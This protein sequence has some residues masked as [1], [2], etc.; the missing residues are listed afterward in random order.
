ARGRAASRAGAPAGGSS[1]GRA[2]EATG[3]AGGSPSGDG[4]T[5]GEALA[6]LYDDRW[7]AMV[8]LATFLTGSLPLAE[9]LVQ[10]VFERLARRPDLGRQPAAYLRASVVNA[11]RSAARRQARERRRPVPRSDLVVEPIVPDESGELWDLLDRLTA[12]QRQALV[13][14]YWLDLAD[15]DIAA[16]VGCRPGTVRTLTRRG[17]ARLRA[18]MEGPA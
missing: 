15:A 8:R 10:D 14:R 1:G 5:Q 13:L 17:L 3:T 7:V 16:A 9:D 6:E 12:R 2:G 4:G 11:C 18:A